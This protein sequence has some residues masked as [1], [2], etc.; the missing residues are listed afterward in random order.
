MIDAETNE[1]VWRGWAEESIS[2]DNFEDEVE[3][4][5]DDIFDEYPLDDD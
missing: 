5:V 4:Y 2:P 3:D 1:I